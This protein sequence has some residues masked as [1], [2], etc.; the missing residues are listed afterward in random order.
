MADGAQLDRDDRIRVVPAMQIQ[1]R[2]LGLGLK[3]HS[4]FGARRRGKR[5]DEGAPA[6]PRAEGDEE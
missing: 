2:C 5:K 4:I 3:I 1:I 6:A